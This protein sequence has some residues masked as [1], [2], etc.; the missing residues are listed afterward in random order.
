MKK[1]ATKCCKYYND[2]LHLQPLKEKVLILYIE[3]GELPEWP[4]GH[5]C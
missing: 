4:K 5:V 1:N 2:A 3:F